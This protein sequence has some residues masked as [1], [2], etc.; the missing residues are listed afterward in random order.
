[1]TCQIPSERVA[2]GPYKYCV[3]VLARTSDRT[4]RADIT[5]RITDQTPMTHTLTDSSPT[6]HL[7][8]IHPFHAARSD[9][10]RA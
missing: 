8:L 5:I 3:Y 4:R 10:T 2:G 1:M 9:C 6:D 7:R